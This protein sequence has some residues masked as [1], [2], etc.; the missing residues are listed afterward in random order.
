MEYPSPPKLR[1]LIWRMCKGS[2]ATKQVLYNRYCVNSPWC[3]PCNTDAESIFHALCDCPNIA[4]IWVNSP[5]AA[6]VLRDA[7]RSSI[8]VFLCWIIDHCQ[9]DT[10]LSLCTSLWV[11]WYIRNKEIFS[12][13][14]VDPICVAASYHKLFHEYNLYNAAVRTHHGEY[15]LKFQVWQPPLDDWVKVNFDAHVATANRRGLGIVIRDKVGKI[16]LAVVRSLNANWSPEVSEAAAA[17]YGVELTVRFGY[18]CVHLEGDA[19]NVVR[20]IDQR[21]DGMSPIHLIYEKLFSYLYRF[22]GFCCTFVSRNG[23]SLAHSIAIWD[24]GLAQEKVFTEP[25]SQ[26]LLALAVLDL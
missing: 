17:L 23:N 11:A 1:H 7:P 21:L 19:I 13:E 16:L 14:R 8:P 18:R 25:F 3:D 24:T 12:D 6:V 20:A 22:D 5:A 4:S 2:L 26:E 10:F 9:D 15:L